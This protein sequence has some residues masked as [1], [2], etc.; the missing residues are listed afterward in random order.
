MDSDKF[1]LL[2]QGIEF[3]QR[4]LHLDDSLIKNLSRCEV[5]TGEQ[6]KIIIVSFEG[7][8][9]SIIIEMYVLYKA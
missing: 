7:Y 5:I 9:Y 6:A 2:T 3:L 4:N 8:R 1:K